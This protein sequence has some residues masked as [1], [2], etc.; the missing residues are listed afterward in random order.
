MFL[1]FGALCTSECHEALYAATVWC[2]RLGVSIAENRTE[3]PKE[4][5]VFLGIEI[6]TIRESGLSGD[7]ATF[8]REAAVL[9]HREIKQWIGK[10]S[11]IKR[12]LL[13]SLIGQL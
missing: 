1:L 8:G 10:K 13:L 9:A 4:G 6:D 7:R 5:T 12:D 3:G 2:S 11:C